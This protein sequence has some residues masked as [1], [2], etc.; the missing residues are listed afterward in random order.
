M[1]DIPRTLHRIDM[2]LEPN[3]ASPLNPDAASL[4]NNPDGGFSPVRIAILLMVS[5][6]FKTQ[7]M[8]H[9]RPLENSA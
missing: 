8:K 5:V 9:Y 3:N 4:W 2:V 6:A 7:L 1:D